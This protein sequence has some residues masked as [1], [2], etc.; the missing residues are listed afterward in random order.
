[1]TDRYCALHSEYNAMAK[2]ANDYKA[3]M[4]WTAQVSNTALSQHQHCF[5]PA[6]FGANNAL[7]EQALNQHCLVPTLPRITSTLYQLRRVPALFDANTVWRQHCLAPTL[8]GANT[9][10]Y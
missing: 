7:C 5:V 3:S 10:L 2:D 8:F 9:S 6:L 1:M 4:V